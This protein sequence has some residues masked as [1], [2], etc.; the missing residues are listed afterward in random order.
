MAFLAALSS[1]RSLNVRLLVVLSVGLLGEI[2]EKVTYRVSTCTIFIF[3]NYVLYSFSSEIVLLH[4]KTEFDKIQN[5]KVTKKRVTSQ[6]KDKTQSS[7]CDQTKKSNCDKSQKIQ[8]VTKLKKLK[9]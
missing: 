7:N 8:I 1:F 3:V 6:D 5:S 2:C 9:L 4:S